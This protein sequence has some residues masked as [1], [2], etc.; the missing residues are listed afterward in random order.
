MATVVTTPKVGDL[1]GSG[2]W[3]LDSRASGGSCTGQMDFGSVFGGS[4]HG[5][6][7]SIGNLGI[8][9]DLM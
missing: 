9:V 5:P 1:G 3:S 6:V 4:E 2:D 7:E 8:W